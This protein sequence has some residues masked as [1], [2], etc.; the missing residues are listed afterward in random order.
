[1]DAGRKRGDDY[2]ND[3]ND[4]DLIRFDGGGER[5]AAGCPRNLS[6]NSAGNWRPF[7]GIDAKGIFSR[8]GRSA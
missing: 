8:F 1:M 3:C 4:R 5:K 6:V 2:V 7:S